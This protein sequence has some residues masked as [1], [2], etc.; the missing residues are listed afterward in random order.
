M[1]LVNAEDRPNM[2][3]T[4]EAVEF[5]ASVR[6]ASSSITLDE[7]HRLRCYSHSRGDSLIQHLTLIPALL[8]L[9]VT[10]CY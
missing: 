5:D 4:N 7:L 2:W 10:A 8:L 6:A 3:W 1:L 9:H